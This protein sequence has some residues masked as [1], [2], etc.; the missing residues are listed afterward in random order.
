MVLDLQV[1]LVKNRARHLLREKTATTAIIVNDLCGN[2]PV[3]GEISLVRYASRDF[4]RK[5]YV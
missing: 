3:A 2:R 5:E 1:V 4:L